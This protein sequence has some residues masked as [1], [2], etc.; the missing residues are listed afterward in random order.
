[1]ENIIVEKKL[2]ISSDYQYKALQSS[3]FI[4][5]N[6]HN[7]KLVVLDYILKLTKAK[8]VLDL[9]TGSGN[10]ELKFAKKLDKIVGVDYNDEA[11]EF[12][13][14]K[15]RKNKINNVKLVVND[16]K[17]IEKI[18]N[19]PKFDLIIMVDVIE[20]LKIRDAEK[21]VPKLKDLVKKGGSVCIITPNYKSTWLIL[22]QV[23]DIFTILPHFEGEQHLAKY[24]KQNL[25]SLFTRVG[26]RPVFDSSFNLF[27]FLFFNKPI[28]KWL[29]KLEVALKLPFGNLI[30]SLFKLRD[31]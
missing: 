8:S 5:S 1:M 12:L 20:H 31:I 29:C 25:E 13:R 28:A 2:G 9:G 23:L 10:F 7:N 18:K 21:L 14:S 11:I 17:E 27:S 16:I 15:L 26:F 6:W 22:E 19:F 3:N 24:Y 30:V 4:Q